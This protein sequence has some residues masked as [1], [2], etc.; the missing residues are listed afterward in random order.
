M[1][2]FEV[3]CTLVALRGFIMET[4]RTEGIVEK[5]V[6]YVKDMFGTPPYHRHVDS[7]GR[8][9]MPT[10]AAETEVTSDDAM[11]LDPYSSKASGNS[12]SKARDAM[13]APKSPLAPPSYMT[14]AL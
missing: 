13:T 3:A 2:N 6:A 11:R 14:M 5:A 8:P 9:I 12:T 4:E 7:E 10:T 1:R